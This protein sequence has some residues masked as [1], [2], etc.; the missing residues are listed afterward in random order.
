MCLSDLVCVRQGRGPCYVLV[1]TWPTRPDLKAR[2]LRISVLALV[3][4][5]D[6]ARV[7]TLFLWHCVSFVLVLGLGFIFC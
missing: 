2:C 3:Q 4:H 7:L 1:P 5:A 6:V